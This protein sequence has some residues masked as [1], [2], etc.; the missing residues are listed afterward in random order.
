MP[1]P[2][3][4]PQGQPPIGSSP[5]TGP[6]QNL[7]LAAK[8]MQAAGA[9]LNAMAMVIPLVGAGSP[10]GQA[11]AKAMVD[12]GKHVPPGT[13]SP[14]GESEFVKQMALRQQQM[15]SQRAALASQQPP[16]GAAPGAAPQPPRPVAA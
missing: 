4:P 9:L 1:S 2:G 6:S 16:P 3:G 13:A 11:L 12:I 8:G 15:G 10:I 7:G 14:Q 5:A